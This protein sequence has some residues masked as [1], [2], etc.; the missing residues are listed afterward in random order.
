MLISEKR[1]VTC[2]LRSRSVTYQLTQVNAPCLNRSQTGRCSV[3]L[4][5]RDGRLSWLYTTRRHELLRSLTCLCLCVCIQKPTDELSRSYISF[6]RVSLDQMRQ[7]VADELYILT[8]FEV[9]SSYSLYSSFYTVRHKNTPYF[10][11]HN[12]HNTWPILI[13]IDVQCLW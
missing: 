13:E 8:L 12:F 11:C 2:H 1:S 7:N 6:M 3:Y 4:P 10:F 5:R 9:L